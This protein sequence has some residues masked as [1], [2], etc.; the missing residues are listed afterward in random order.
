MNISLV[1]SDISHNDIERNFSNYEHLLSLVNE[2]TDIIVFPEMFACGFSDD[3]AGYGEQYYQQ[4][5]D[6]LQNISQK[7][8]ADVV[9]SLPVKE[10][11]FLFNRLLWVRGN[12]I[13]ANYDKRHL[14]FGCEKQFCTKGK[15]KT[16]VGVKDWNILPLICY[17]IRFPLWCRNKYENNTML[18]D[19]LLFIANFPTQRADTLRTLLVARAIENQAYVVCLNRVGEDAYN[20]SH[21]GNSIIV[22]PLGEII[23][24][25]HM[26]EQYVLNAKMEWNV[27]DSL[28]KHFPV[29]EDW[30]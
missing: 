29:Y 9:A 21:N 15:N 16:I 8:H 4:S 18:Y 7:H 6:F 27:L 10:N 19:C 17:D 12:Q 20:N 5:V 1:Q 13:V 28:R 25:A 24:E 30:D 26:N 11:D 22:N 23:A 14:F 3:I 2:N